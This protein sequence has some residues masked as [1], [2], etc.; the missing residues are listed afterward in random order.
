LYFCEKEI[1]PVKI[2]VLGNSS[3][4]PRA[5]QHPSAHVVAL[6]HQLF[7]VDCGEGTQYQ[8]I[9]HKIKYG[10]IDHVFIS[11]LH[12]D[13]FFGLLGLI[14]TYYLNSRTRPLH[15]YAH[16][17]LEGF[18]N[19]ML[20][21]TQTT[22]GFPIVFHYL[23]P[24]VAVT[25][26]ETDSV[27]VN[28][29]PLDHRV[30][31]HGFLFSDKRDPLKSYAYCSDT[32][33]APEIVPHV[34]NVGL[35]YHEATFGDDKEESAAQKF[36]STARQAAQIAAMAN[37]KHLLIGHFSAKY[38]SPENLLAQAREVFPNANIAEEGRTYEL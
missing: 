37:A 24:E 38:P 7:L 32:R 21:L 6:H 12:G 35:L 14:T 15:I 26:Y 34:K 9:R 36:H 16:Q 29:F 31:A 30:D 4:S 3:A 13:H 19:G 18:V 10:G 27:R 28:V 20:E 2:T 25:I 8:L 33:F 22:L 1:Y 23:K 11:H 5:G 17:Q